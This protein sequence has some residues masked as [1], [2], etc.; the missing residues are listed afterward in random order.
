ME[1]SQVFHEITS[2]HDFKDMHDFL[3]QQYTTEIVY[4]ERKNIYQAFDLTP[5][6][7]VKVVILGQDPYHGPNQAHGLAFS[8]Q[9]NAKFPPSL[10]NMYKELADDI[11]CTRQSPHLQDWAKEGVLLLNTVLTVR[12]GEAHSHRNIGW[13]TFTDEVIQAVSNYHEHIVFI[14]WGKPAQQKIKLIDT[15]KHCIIKSVHPSP[16]SA[17]RGFFGSKP[18]SKANDYLISVGKTPVNW[19]ENESAGDENG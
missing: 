1:W 7:D 6:E 14:L 8:V 18:Y 15:T 13:E 9:P 19:C 10:R 17:Y 16:L 4:P 12:K 3:E 2:R 5:F 11:G